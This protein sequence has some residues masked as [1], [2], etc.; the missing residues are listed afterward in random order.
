MANNPSETLCFHCGLATDKHSF[1]TLKALGKARY[2]C[3]MGCYSVCQI[4]VESGLDDYYN[5][6][7]LTDANPAE[8]PDFLEKYQLY[9][10]AHIQKSFV[11]QQGDWKEAYLLLEN[12]RCPACVWL[13]EKNL[14]SL[15]GVLEVYIDAVSNRARVKWLTKRT[16]LSTILKSIADTGYLAHPYDAKHSRK[17]DK[18]KARRNIEKLLFALIIGM[19]LMQFSIA[20]YLLDTL[21]DSGEML[22]WV[23]LGRWGASLGSFSLLIYPAQDFYIGAWQDIKRRRVG[24]DLPVVIGLSVAFLAS[25]R[26]VISQRG[27]VYFDT[28]AMFILFVLLARFLEFR[29]R[30]KS[31]SQLDQLNI[32]IAQS[33]EK[34][35][36]STKTW[37]KAAVIDLK[38]NDLVRVKPGEVVMADGEI[39][40]GN[41]SFDESLLTGEAQLIPKS[42][43]EHVIAGSINHQ[44][45]VELRINKVGSQTLLS[46]IGKIAMRAL[47]Q[48]PAM[49][50][51]AE[52]VAGWFVLGVLLISLASAG[53]WLMQNNSDW[54]AHTIAV[55]IVTCPCA[56]ALATPVALT[57]GMERLIRQG[58]L[59]LKTASLEALAGINQVAFDKTGTLTT[60]KMPVLATELLADISRKE[61]VKLACSLASYSEHIVSRALVAEFGVNDLYPISDFQNNPGLGI[62]AKINHRIWRLGRLDKSENDGLSLAKYQGKTIS[63]LSNEQGVQAFFVLQ[64]DIRNFARETVQ[65]LQKMGIENITL[66]SGDNAES[67]AKTAKKIGIKKHLANCLPQDKL[68]WLQAQQR[69]GGRILFVGDGVNDAPILAG[70][71]LSLSLCDASDIANT[72]SDFIVLNNRIDGVIRALKSAK[73]IKKI[74]RQNLI[75]AAIYNLTA[76]PLAAAGIVPP[77]LAAIGMSFSSLLV[78]LNAQ[79]LRSED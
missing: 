48:K 9:D 30:R 32:V 25:T 79:R 14:R 19:L 6:R 35:Q 53:Y 12:I 47:E 38:A 60:G 50:S 39:V 33:C 54:L 61:A 49:V 59:P 24:M 55:L 70:A 76:V 75:W 77:W 1:P 36:E 5:Y 56:L 40:T 23:I 2:F 27:E 65:Q 34:W 28:I 13:N 78:V 15:D 68:A 46:Q 45:T 64:D 62:Q 66:L 18:I 3:C 37:A 22:D 43:G 7:T 11:V 44:Q 16:K 73:L 26:S 71:D 72:H 42:L 31:V 63:F 29:G 51:Q 57:S 20:S 58:V 67:V 10:K 21:N 69:Q 52:R 8:L 74:I 4:I 41:S 17:L